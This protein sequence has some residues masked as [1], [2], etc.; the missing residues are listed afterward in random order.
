MS[1]RITP[2]GHRDLVR[3]LHRFGWEG[4]IP[5]S[6][7]FH[8]VHRDRRYPLIIPNPHSG[9]E[10]GVPLLRRILRQAGI[11]RDEWLSV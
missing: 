8:M 5:G 6:K 1:R 11:S 3:K 9:Q 4:P 10:V 7:H 2:V